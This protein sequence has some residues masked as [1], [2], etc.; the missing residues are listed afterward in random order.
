MQSRLDPPTT[1]SEF[2][3][4]LDHAIGARGMSLR[5]LQRLLSER[6]A[7]SR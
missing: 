1:G 5:S 6:E 3:Q 2:A 4:A 7:P